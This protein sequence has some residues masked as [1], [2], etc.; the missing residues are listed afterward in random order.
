MNTLKN[1]KRYIKEHNQLLSSRTCKKQIPS[2]VLPC[3][4]IGGVFVVASA[5]P[6]SEK[7]G[8]VDVKSRPLVVD[9]D[10]VA[11]EWVAV[12]VVV[13]LLIDS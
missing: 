6:T 10:S 9:V 5:K 3:R 2:A 11:K 13:F 1:N 12:G 7:G 8:V 4:I